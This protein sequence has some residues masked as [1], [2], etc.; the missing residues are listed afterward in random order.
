MSFPR[1]MTDYGRQREMY[2]RAQ[3]MIPPYAQQPDSRMHFVQSYQQ[4]PRHQVSQ[5]CPSNERAMLAHQQRLRHEQV[6]AQR[7]PSRLPLSATG[8]DALQV[9]QAEMMR[10]R[11]S[12]NGRLPRSSHALHGG[13]D[14]GYYNVGQRIASSNGLPL[15]PSSHGVSYGIPQPAVSCVSSSRCVPNA[16]GLCKAD[17]V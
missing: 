9:L 15:G 1:D 8:E 11:L 5:I 3:G 10:M 4:Q 6:M 14:N 17:S 7:P 12:E 13:H 2:S 16:L